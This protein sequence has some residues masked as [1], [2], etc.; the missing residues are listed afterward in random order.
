MDHTKIDSKMADF[1]A[2]LVFFFCFVYFRANYLKNF[3]AWSEV[4]QNGDKVDTETTGLL[5]K[6]FWRK[7]ASK[8]TAI[9]QNGQNL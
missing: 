6:P 8:L 5:T 2:F 1:H 7:L 3:E 4:R 9:D